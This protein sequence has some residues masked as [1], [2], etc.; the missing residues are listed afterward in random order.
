MWMSSAPCS[1]HA[2]SALR[3][4]SIVH[5]VRSASTAAAESA[6]SLRVSGGSLSN[7]LLLTQNSEKMKASPSTWVAYFTTS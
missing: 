2:P 3:F 4:W 5:L 6:I 1:F 7:Q